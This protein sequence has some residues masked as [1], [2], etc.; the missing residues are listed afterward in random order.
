MNCQQI[1]KNFTQKGLTEVKIFQNV[2]GGYFFETPCRITGQVLPWTNVIRYLGIF[3]VQSRT[4][5]CSIDE[6]KRSFYS[7]ANAIFG[8]IGRFA[9]EEVTLHL[10]KTKCVHSFVPNKGAKFGA[11]IF[12]SFRGVAI[13]IRKLLHLRNS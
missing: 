2:S 3:I 6:A 8:K 9:S 5:K 7:A 11:K 13:F 1:R 4:F 12:T 10:L